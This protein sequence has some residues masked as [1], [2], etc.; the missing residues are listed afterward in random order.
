MFLGTY[1]PSLDDKG[2]LILP[3]R[4]REELAAGLVVTKGQE[5]CLAVWTAE[6]FA[7]LTAQMRSASRPGSP[8]A[9]AGRSSRDYHRVFFASAYDCQ[10]DTQGRIVIPAPLREY[11]GLTR[12]CV[13]IGADT[14]L[15]VWD[16]TAWSD[17]LAQAESAFSATGS[18]AAP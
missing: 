5:R 8:E 14:R 15:E 2:R 6:G 12:E 1:T 13:V 4:F 16:A 18:E 11:A 3:A 17:Y 7:E 10:P 9:A